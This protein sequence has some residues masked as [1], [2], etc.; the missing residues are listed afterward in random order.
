MNDSATGTRATLR[1][2]ATATQLTLLCRSLTADRGLNGFTIEEVCSDIGI[3]RRTFFNYFPSKEDAVLGIADENDEMSKMADD[4][5]ARGSR[6]WTAVVDDLADLAVQHIRSAGHNASEHIAFMTVLEREPRLLAR[7][8]GAG[9]EREQGLVAMVAAREGVPADDPLARAAID[10]VSTILRS[11]AD[12]ISDPR[13]AEDFGAAI[14]E[15]LA[16]VRAVLTP[17]LP[18]KADQ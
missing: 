10:I 3:S 2:Q 13:V 15:S 8:I 9:R 12:R 14:L 5:R 7:F 4:F 16:A 17:P 18:R 6:G 11:T 1:K